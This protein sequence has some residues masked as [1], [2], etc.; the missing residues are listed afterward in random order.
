[1]N[2]NK[3]SLEQTTGN[4]ISVKL[5]FFLILISGNCFSQ[6]HIC[7][8]DKNICECDSGYTFK[9]DIDNII[10]LYG[11]EGNMVIENILIKGKG[12]KIKNVDSGRFNVSV[13]PH[14][15]QRSVQLKIFGR[16]N[17]ELIGTRNVDISDCQFDFKINAYSRENIMSV[18]LDTIFVVP[19]SVCKQCDSITVKLKSSEILIK[20]GEET[21]FSFK[22]NS[23]LIPESIKKK[24]NS[25]LRP[26]DE[27]YLNNIHLVL[28]KRRHAFI[29]YQPILKIY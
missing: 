4:C 11:A 3:T 16:G 13:K 2:S 14:F 26:G 5:L 10:I 15:R 18:R 17:R 29:K 9:R 23:S 12:L 27:V 25:M 6:I 8:I 19:V 1:M 7:S 21:V 24:Y 28:N 22:V 20:R